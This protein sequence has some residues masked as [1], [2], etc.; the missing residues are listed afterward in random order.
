VGLTWF[1]AVA[2][3]KTG[4]ILPGWTDSAWRISTRSYY[5]WVVYLGLFVLAFSIPLWLS[6]SRRKI[7][8]SVVFVSP[9]LVMS[10]A[11]AYFWEQ[12][13]PW[14]RDLRAEWQET[15]ELPDYMNMTDEEYWQLRAEEEESR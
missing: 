10:L 3:A 7:V 1:F 14:D 13:P 2:F 4:L 9:L 11:R 12:Y 5:L 8:W 15:R 6:K